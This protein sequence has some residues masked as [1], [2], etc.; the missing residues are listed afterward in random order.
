MGIS[1]QVDR[2]VPHRVEG[3]SPRDHDSDA[4]DKK[5]FFDSSARMAETYLRPEE[6]LIPGQGLQFFKYALQQHMEDR[7]ESFKPTAGKPPCLD[8]LRPGSIMALWKGFMKHFD[9]FLFCKF[10]PPKEM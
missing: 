5:I 7:P 6:Q 1:R 9:I 2:N 8:D 4:Q 10:V 3:A